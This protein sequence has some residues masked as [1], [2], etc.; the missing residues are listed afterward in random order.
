MY[1]PRIR[2]Y[3]KRNKKLKLNGYGSYAEFLRSDMWLRIKTVLMEKPQ[4]KECFFCKS[5]RGIVLHHSRYSKVN[6]E[7][8]KYLLPVCYQCHT[9]IHRLELDKDITTLDATREWSDVF[10][11]LSKRDRVLTK[12]FFKKFWGTL[13]I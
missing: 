5:S 2:Q 10:R 7:S 12:T 9:G 8:A 11:P 4:S 13:K 3:Y 6:I 1:S